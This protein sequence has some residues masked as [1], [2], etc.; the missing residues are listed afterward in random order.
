M[1]S[2][3]IQPSV[4]R[5]TRRERVGI[6]ALGG[7]IVTAIGAYLAL[8][9]ATGRSGADGGLLPYQTLTRTLPDADQR[10]FRAIRQGLL[11]LEQERTR[12]SQW[13]RPADLLAEGM[14]PFQA[15]APSADYNW[16][17]YQQGTTV[18]YFGSPADPTRPAWLLSI[19]EP[20]PGMLPDPA[21]NDEEHHRLP[22]GTVLHIYVWI[23]RYGGQVRS[24]FVTQP[25]T[26]GWIE[27][28][29]VPPNPT[30]SR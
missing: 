22:D 19:R 11:V 17:R 24:S 16:D 13:P 30:A 3:T 28:F 7:L 21:P 5:S 2:R 20:D 25:Q 6:F 12:T 9:A 23:H 18:N 8:N 14:A 27:I 1:T 26:E 29:A 15:D 4:G 10:Q